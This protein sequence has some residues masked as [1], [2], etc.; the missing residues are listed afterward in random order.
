MLLQLGEDGPD[1]DDLGDH[2]E[3]CAAAQRG[4]ETEE[5]VQSHAAG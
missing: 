2:A 4:D 5:G 1:R 3:C